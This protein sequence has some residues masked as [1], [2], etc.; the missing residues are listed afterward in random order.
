MEYLQYGISDGKPAIKLTLLCL[1]VMH[2]KNLMIIV[3]QIE[4]IGRCLRS[5]KKI[6]FHVNNFGVFVSSPVE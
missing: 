4:D 2:S 6:K 1:G 3:N 5:S